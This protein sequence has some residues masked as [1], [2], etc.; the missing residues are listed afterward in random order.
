[1]LWSSFQEQALIAACGTSVHRD[2]K[3]CRVRSH[4][5]LFAIPHHIV[6]SWKPFRS[7]CLNYII[8]LPTPSSS[9]PLRL[10]WPRQD[11]SMCSTSADHRHVSPRRA[12]LLLRRWSPSASWWVRCA[13]LRSWSLVGGLARLVSCRAPRGGSVSRTR[14]TLPDCRGTDQLWE[15]RASD[16][17]ECPCRHQAVE[18]PNARQGQRGRTRGHTGAEDSAGGVRQRIE[19]SVEAD[20]L[21]QG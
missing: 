19:S 12:V 8:L 16:A 10:H 3:L 13:P 5:L 18:R 6:H 2:S 1:M 7:K 15:E 14:C 4:G 21:E 11:G 17:G 9:T 20:P